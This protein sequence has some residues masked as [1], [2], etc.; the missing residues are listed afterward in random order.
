MA[1]RSRPGA[2]PAFSNLFLIKKKVQP[3]GISERFAAT[4]APTKRITVSCRSGGSRELGSQ[5][6]NLDR[7]AEDHC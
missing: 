3:L 4:A 1:E 5:N 2:D 6:I 7:M